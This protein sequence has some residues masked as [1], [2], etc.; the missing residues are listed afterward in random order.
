MRKI[1]MCIAGLFVSMCMFAQNGSDILDKIK[2]ANTSLKSITGDFKQI[3]HLPIMDEDALSNGKFYYRKPDR[4]CLKYDEPEG[5]IMLIRGD[6]IFMVII[7]EYKKI[8]AK[9]DPSVGLIH[10]IFSSSLEGDTRKIKDATIS[11]EEKG[12]YYEVTI[13][14]NAEKAKDIQRVKT[15]YDKKDMAFSLLRIEYEDGAYTTYELV[16]KTINQPIADDVFREPS[17]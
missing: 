1:N 7:D 13:N 16:R 4:L 17:K 6:Q 8:S 9:T 14:I 12:N 3:A 5:E 15:R 2:Q 10:S 11:A